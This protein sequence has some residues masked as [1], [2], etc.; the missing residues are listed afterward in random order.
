MLDRELNAT[1]AQTSAFLEIGE[2]AF[3]HV[4]TLLGAMLGAPA[5]PP[6]AP[7]PVA[8]AGAGG[9]SACAA[10]K[11]G[12]SGETPADAIDLAVDDD[13]A[14]APLAPPARV[15]V[16]ALDAEH[17]AC[18][19]AL[20]ALGETRSAA[21]LGAVRE[22]YAAHFAHEEA[23]LDAHVYAA[24]SDGSGAFSADANVRRL[25]R[26]TTRRAAPGKKRGRGG[27]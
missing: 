21:A 9:C 17:D 24:A 1:C 12:E 4:E 14:V 22:L 6:P 7:L 23:L 20:D 10:V 19:A 11:F 3:A 15:D 8:A 13:A 16:A 2:R 27:R 25:T 26:R 5:A 18:H